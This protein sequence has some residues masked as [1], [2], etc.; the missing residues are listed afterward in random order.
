MHIH[1]FCLSVVP[2]HTNLHVLFYLYSDGHLIM[3]SPGNYQI[4]LD[5][6]LI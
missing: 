3:I 2:C 5:A 1:G 4:T 6:G